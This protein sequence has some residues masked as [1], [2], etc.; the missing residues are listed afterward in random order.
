M[1]SRRRLTI[2]SIVVVLLTVGGV[3]TYLLWPAE[4]PTA[5]PVA[6]VMVEPRSPGVLPG[7]TPMSAEDV[8]AFK[9]TQ[10]A[11]V[12]SEF[13]ARSAMRNPKVTEILRGRDAEWLTERITVEHKQGSQVISIGVTGVPPA[14]AAVLA[15]A[16]A[17]ALVR[18]ARQMEVTAST[19]HQQRLLEARTKL[20]QLLNS[21]R[22]ALE[23]KA[24]TSGV[25]S[26]KAAQQALLS[27]LYQER[28]GL[29]VELAKA[30]A[31]GKPAEKL[32]PLQDDLT[33]VEERITCCER[34]G[35]DAERA[36]VARLEAAIAALATE[37]MRAELGLRAPPRVQL[38]GYATDSKTAMAKNGST[39]S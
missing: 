2:L 19:H 38:L 3:A 13:V 6:V 20:E 37:Q 12:K 15:D 18:E 36:E 22:Q 14:D 4:K 17:E 5:S 28:A 35:P 1:F 24:A 34:V 7:G 23:Q 16:V 9:K 33:A 11:L 10:V 8:D 31:D 25:P 32:T 27:A 26:D 39:G 29:R 30:R 21:Q